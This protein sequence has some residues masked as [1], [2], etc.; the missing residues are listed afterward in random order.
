MTNAKFWCKHFVALPYLEVGVRRE[1]AEWALARF[2]SQQ[3]DIFHNNPVGRPGFYFE[4]ERDA[5][6]FAL[7]WSDNR[8]AYT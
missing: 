6:L 2:G 4:H 3:V 8:V 1:A 5:I 7:K